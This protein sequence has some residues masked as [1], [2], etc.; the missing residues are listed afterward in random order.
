MPEKLGLFDRG[1]FS[2]FCL[3]RAPTF[4]RLFVTHTSDTM[5]PAKSQSTPPAQS[6]SNPRPVLAHVPANPSGLRVSHTLSSPE[7]P[8]MILGAAD[9]SRSPEAIPDTRPNSNGEQSEPTARTRLLEHQGLDSRPKF[10]QHYGS[11]FSTDLYDPREGLESGTVTPHS[12]LDDNFFGAAS[13]SNMSTT[14]W[15]AK[16]HGVK[17][18][19]TMYVAK[20]LPSSF[21]LPSKPVFQ[22]SPILSPCDQ[23]DP[24]VSMEIPTR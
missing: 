17:S 15:L 21:V 6:S 19:R 3:F 5:P 4:S 16:Q 20:S 10:M 23:L 12:M 8:S 14:R 18:E 1:I 22:V 9:R 7:N 11:T 2:V 24:P 13:G